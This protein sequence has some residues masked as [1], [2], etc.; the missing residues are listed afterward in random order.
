MPILDQSEFLD[1][2]NLE[3]EKETPLYNWSDK[4]L[5]LIIQIKLKSIQVLKIG[6]LY[7]NY[8]KKGWL[9]SYVEKIEDTKYIFEGIK[10]QTVVDHFKKHVFTVDLKYFDADEYLNSLKS[11]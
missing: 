3:I 1:N 4:N 8:E 5:L 11:S 7:I 9:D 10:G 2:P 6:K